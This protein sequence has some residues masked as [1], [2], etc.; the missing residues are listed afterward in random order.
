MNSFV[1][2]NLARIYAIQAE[3]DGM[4]A[5]NW[6]RVM[7]GLTIAYGEENFLAKSSQLQQIANH[8]NEMRNRGL[9]DS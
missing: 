4:K 6:M 1:V 3:I 8:L 5:E 9:I 7:Q 2:E